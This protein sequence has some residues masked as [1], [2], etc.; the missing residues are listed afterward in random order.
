MRGALLSLLVLAC[1]LPAAAGKEREFFS[2]AVLADPHIAGSPDATKRLAKCVGWL[3]RHRE[4]E[5]LAFVS[6]VGD[7]AWGKGNTERAKKLLDRLSVPYLPVIGDNEV[8]TGYAKEFNRVFGPHLDGLTG[9]LDGFRRAPVPVKAPG[10]DRELFLQNFSF[11]HGGV[12]FIG[13][14]WVT[15]KGG[16]S[17]DLHDFPGG[18]FRWWGK[19]VERVASRKKR[20]VVLFSHLPMH[21]NYLIEVFS[22][23]EQA[24]VEKRIAAW[25][26]ALYACFAGHY[27]MK[28]VEMR[29]GY[30][31]YV[32]DAVWDDTISIRMVRVYKGEDGFDYKQRVVTLR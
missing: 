12:H 7:I 19:D 21:V 23:E 8:E 5:R 30:R 14:D 18:T 9:K 1:L 31:L 17:A 25:K 27:H 28:W 24:R 32:T 29:P 22:E 11:D 4:R 20:S 10:S 6:V 2:F 16:E 3:N 26:G 15:R 13:L